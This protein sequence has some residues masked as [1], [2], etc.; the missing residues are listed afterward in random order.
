[1]RMGFLHLKACRAFPPLRWFL[2]VSPRLYVPHIALGSDERLLEFGCGAGLS[3]THFNP[4]NYVGVDID[5]KRVEFAKQINPG[6]AYQK[7]SGPS[8]P[9]EYAAFDWILAIAV[10]HHISDADTVKILDD[11]SRVLKP[12]KSIIVVEPYLANNRLLNFWMQTID[13]GQF[14]RSQKDY[15]ALFERYFD[16][17]ILDHLLAPLMFSLA[18]FRLK[19]KD[20]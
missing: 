13:R 14:I 18:T 3:S 9:F 6:Y 17:E 4:K 10:F 11:L 5:G 15:R 20:R 19:K 2:Q 16:V 7:I 8:L 1:M 12:N